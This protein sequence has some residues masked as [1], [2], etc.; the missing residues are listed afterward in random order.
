MRLTTTITQRSIIDA[1]MSSYERL[2]TY[3]KQSATGKRINVPSDDPVGLSR[4]MWLLNSIS[5]NEQYQANIDTALDETRGFSNVIQNVIDSLLRVKEIANSN[6]NGLTSQEAMNAGAYEIEEILNNIVASANTNINNKYMFSGFQT[7]TI[8]F[9][10]TPYTPPPGP[11]IPAGLISAVTY[12]GDT[13]RRA[14]EIDTN[15]TVFVNFAGSS[16]VAGSPGVFVDTIAGVNIFNSLIQLR[17]D[18]FQGNIA[19]IIST[20]E[21]ALSRYVNYLQGL[22]GQMA[23]T[24]KEMINVKDSLQDAVLYKTGIR[25]D[26]EEADP[27]VV[28]SN[29]SNEQ[30]AYQVALK[31]A[32]Q[33]FSVNLF[34]FLS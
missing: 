7:D 6:A 32:A 2:A 12:N 8:P 31:V 13:G 18:L 10:V 21:P 11:P 22:A 28:M 3:Q 4:T 15:R 5:Q 20:D 26:I 23:V 1:I 19:N 34:D 27:Y 25:A 14:M 30:V 17:N 29:M 24:S 9:T 33:V 16:G